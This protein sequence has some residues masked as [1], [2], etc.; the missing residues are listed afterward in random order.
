MNLKISV[1]IPFFYPTKK[2]IGAEEYFSL[3]AFEKCLSAIFN[4]DYKNYE[5]IAVSDF[6]NKQSIKI[7]QKYPC[8]IIKLKKNFGSGYSRNKGARLA[9]G[10]ILVFLDSDVEVKKDA[11]RIINER[12][13]SNS[14][15]IALQ[16]VFSHAPNYKKYTTQEDVDGI[17]KD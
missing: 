7:A 17:C 5:V 11:L 6:S 1:I 13:K 4:S 8:K 16:G 2:I 15:D 10:K 12:Y 3:F 9:K 14:D